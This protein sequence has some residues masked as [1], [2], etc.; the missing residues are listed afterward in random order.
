MTMHVWSPQ[1]GRGYPA[2]TGSEMLKLR[3]HSR[4]PVPLK[5]EDITFIID[6]QQVLDGMRFLFTTVVRL[7][8]F[9]G[10]GTLNRTLSAIMKKRVPKPDSPQRSPQAC[11]PVKGGI[12]NLMSHIAFRHIVCYRHCAPLERQSSSE[13]ENNTN[14][15]NPV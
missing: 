6:Y 9:C 10:F 4:G 7:L 5:K 2:H 13:I 1:Y 14:L 3:I 11:Q 15:V 8:R 12:L